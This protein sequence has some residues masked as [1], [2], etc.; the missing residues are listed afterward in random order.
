MFFSLP[1]LLWSTRP[2]TWNKMRG[3]EKKFSHFAIDHSFSFS[4][5]LCLPLPLP[6]IFSPTPL[7]PSPP[8]TYTQSVGLLKNISFK[9]WFE[10]WDR[11]GWPGFR[12]GECSRLLT[13]HKKMTFDQASVCVQ[14]EYREWKYQKMSEVGGLAYRFS[15]VQSSSQEQSSWGN[16]NREKSLYCIRESMGNQWS[17]ARWGEMWSVLET[18]RTRRAALFWTFCSLFRRYWGQPERRQLQ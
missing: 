16:Y 8:P 15:G 4:L 6:T 10:G 9:W 11:V 3:G 13:Q 7:S 14:W 12:K 18:L 2:I 1:F 17:G 5:S